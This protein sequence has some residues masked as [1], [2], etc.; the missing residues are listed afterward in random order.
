MGLGYIRGAGGGGGVTSDE[1]TATRADVLDGKST[2]TADSADEVVGGTMA[3]R[4]NVTATLAINGTYTIP[5]GYHAGSGKVSQ[6]IPTKAAAT[7]YPGASEQTIAAGQYLS[8]AQ[9]IGAVSQ[10]N[11]IG[12]NIKPG[13]TVKIKNAI[14]NIF[15]VASTMASKAAATYYA[16]TSDQTIAAGQYLSGAQT[17]KKLTQSNMSAANIK[18]GTTVT[19]NNGN[20]NVFSVTGTYTGTKHAMSATA[21]RGFG[22]ASADY[23]PSEENSFTMPLAGVVYYGGISAFYNG[24]GTGTVEIYKNGT[25]VDNRNGSDGYSVRGTMVTKSFTAAKKDVI[26]VMATATAGNGTLCMIQAVCIYLGGT[27]GTV[28]FSNTN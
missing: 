25:L 5:K 21:Y 10:E 18:N 8:G 20:T 2:V 22:L 14:G 26:K 13:I 23:K 7:Y 24:V 1:V 9:K 16:T 3:N 4:G 27:H 19:V 6:S 28:L 12:A 11:L 15:S 17:I